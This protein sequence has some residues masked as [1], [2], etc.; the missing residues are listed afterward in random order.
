M[1]PAIRSRLF[2]SGAT[3]LV[4]VAPFL[5]KGC[6]KPAGAVTVAPPAAER[7]PEASPAGTSAPATGFPSWFVRPPA[8]SNGVLAVGYAPRYEDLASSYAEALS[9]ARVTLARN[10]H[11][12][13]RVEQAVERIGTQTDLGAEYVTEVGADTADV[14]AVPLDSA[15]V[16]D[17][18]VMLVASR[19]PRDLA[20][21]SERV[22]ITAPP[23]AEERGGFVTA[24]GVAP[25]Y[26]YE[27]SSWREAEA[28]ARRALAF[29][30][31]SNQRA[32]RR[33]EGADDQGASVVGANVELVGIQVVGRWR[34]A[35]G[36]H[37]MVRAR[38]GRALA[39]G[40]AP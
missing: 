5:V 26:L 32:I 40:N 18:V 38:A 3:A 4:A 11:T 9:D 34:S 29:T 30:I 39:E 15:V 19:R 6:A 35:A 21:S 25:T 17:V 31:T 7:A 12:V 22:S 10:A 24:T 20:L 28:R 13:L 33:S 36:V 14:A 16:G 27:H 1:R 23:T 2:R 37:V 8:L